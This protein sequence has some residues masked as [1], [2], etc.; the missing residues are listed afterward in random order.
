[1]A[2]LPLAGAILFEVA[3]TT[4]LRAAVTG[5]KKWY[6]V[7]GVGYLL[8]FTMLSFALAQDLPLGVAY[9]VWSATGIAIT[10]I[11]SRFLF[12]EPLTVL[13][14]IGIALVIG[15]VILV[16]TGSAH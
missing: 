7:V 6:L 4:A 1:M 11:L 9:G 3:G 2:W 13:M 10:A 8:S 15:G 12:K 16:E 14:S 5:T